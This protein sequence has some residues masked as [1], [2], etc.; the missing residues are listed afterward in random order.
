MGYKSDHRMVNTKI[1][2]L[3]SWVLW[4]CQQHHIENDKL[5]V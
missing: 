1:L 5:N 2:S 4:D 3:S